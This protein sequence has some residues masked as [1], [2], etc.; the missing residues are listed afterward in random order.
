MALNL[1]LSTLAAIQSETVLGLHDNTHSSLPAMRCYST[2]GRDSGSCSRRAERAGWMVV[3][4]VASTEDL[5]LWDDHPPYFI[6]LSNFSKMSVVRVTAVQRCW[7]KTEC[8]ESHSSLPVGSQ[9]AET[10]ENCIL[11]YIHFYALICRFLDF[12]KL[13][14]FSGYLQI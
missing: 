14:I 8:Q 12:F 3:D 5:Q 1:R 2:V 11:F 13:N 9:A 6:T 7:N 10:T 4:M